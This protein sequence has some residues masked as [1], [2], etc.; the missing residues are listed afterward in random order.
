MPAWVFRRVERAKYNKEADMNAKKLL[1]LAGISTA[2]ASSAVAYD[3][4][5]WGWHYDSQD[6]GWQDDWDDVWEDD[7]V[8]IPENRERARSRDSAKY[9]AKVIAYNRT[10]EWV[11][12]V[13][14]GQVLTWIAPMEKRTL[15]LDANVG[16]I[17]A[18]VGTRVLRQKTIRSGLRE[19]QAF[20]IDPPRTGMVKIKNTLRY[21][22]RVKV[23]GRTIGRISPSSVETFELPTGRQQVQLEAVNGRGQTRSIGSKRIEVEAF[24]KTT[25]VTPEMRRKRRSRSSSRH[26]RSSHSRR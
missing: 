17:S 19:A 4:T 6:Q 21:T 3:N 13:A 5:D 8:Q 12:V 24:E 20:R 26:H 16:Q 18:V 15:R 1:V 2:I 11:K 9:I 14:G 22:V 7:I 25:L 10:Q 23:N